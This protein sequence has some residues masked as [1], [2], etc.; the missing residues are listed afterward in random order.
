MLFDM[1]SPIYA[2]FFNL[3]VR[4]YRG[5]LDKMMAQTYIDQYKTVLD[6]GCGTGALSYVLQEFGKEVVGV[7]TSSG[8]LKR[9]KK[10]LE[11]TRIPDP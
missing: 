2:M 3:Q 5:V 10:K 6:L 8:M 11:G 1:I 7:D 4:Y 9:A